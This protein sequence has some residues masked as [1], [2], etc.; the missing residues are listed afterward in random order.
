MRGN[1]KRWP[2]PRCGDGSIPACAGEP[3][4]I[5]SWRRFH[6]VYPRVCGGTLHR[7]RSLAATTGLSPRVRGNLALALITPDGTGS[8]PA[9][10]GEPCAR[11][12][13]CTRCSGDEVYPRVCGGTTLCLRRNRVLRGLS[14]RVRGNRDV[15]T[16]WRAVKRSI[17]A[18]AGEPISGLTP[19]TTYK[20]YPR[21]CGGTP[22]RP[23]ATRFVHGLSP[24]V[25]GNH[26]RRAMSALYMGSIP[27]CA[28]EPALAFIPS[29][30]QRV[31][32]RVCGGTL[33]CSEHIE[34]D[35]GLSPRVRGNR[36]S[37]MEAAAQNRSIPACAGEPY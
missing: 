36:P 24:R 25:R 16:E 4:L 8:I 3:I 15:R 7:R 11:H 17:P 13:C 18:C 1:P 28:G 30:V 37:M 32:P 6:S 23:R 12:P 20:V 2:G 14:P 31:Y 33:H 9:C 10:A 22:H 19:N 34:A 35:G 26:P 27:A 5:S 21:V 29:A